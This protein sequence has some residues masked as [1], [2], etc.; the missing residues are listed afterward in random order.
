MISSPLFIRHP[1][2]H[3]RMHLIKIHCYCSSYEHHFINNLHALDPRTY[4][5][6]I[7][8]LHVHAS[9]AMLA[10]IVASS[11]YITVEMVS[12]F[13]FPLLNNSSY[14]PLP[15]LHLNNG[16][17]WRRNAFVSVLHF[18]TSITNHC[19][20]VQRMFHQ[21]YKSTSQHVHHY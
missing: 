3:S 1:Y 10:N 9:G 20:L 5:K 18:K 8:S 14:S 16:Q 7:T 13:L 17:R 19:L 21:N 6:L 4:T 12:L 15:K 11:E 2:T